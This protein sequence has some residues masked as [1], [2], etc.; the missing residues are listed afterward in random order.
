MSAVIQFAGAC[1]VTRHGTLYGCNWSFE[2]P[3]PLLPRYWA[4]IVTEIEQL[5]VGDWICVEV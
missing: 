4:Y 3:L 1:D 2:T 5:M